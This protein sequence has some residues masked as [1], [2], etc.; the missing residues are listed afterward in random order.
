[1]VQLA[2]RGILPVFDTPS[3]KLEMDKIYLFALVVTFVVNRMTF[4]ETIL[5]MP[6]IHI[7]FF[8]QQLSL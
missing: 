4:L 6:L 2:F 1:M 7:G 8:H 3:Q 5:T